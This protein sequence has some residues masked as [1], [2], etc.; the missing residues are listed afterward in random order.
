MKIKRALLREVPLRLREYFEIS[1]GGVQERRVVLL[2]LTDAHGVEGFSECVVPEKPNYTAETTDTAWGVLTEYVLP[3]IIGKEWEDPAEVL[4]SL[5]WIRGH[6]MALASVEMAAWDLLA[7]SRGLSLSETLGGTLTEVAVGVSVGLK[8]TDAELLDTVAAYEARGYARVKL[9]IKPGR[10]LEML[11][12]VRERFPGLAIMAD[13]N[14][15]YTMEDLPKFRE[16]DGLGLTMIEQPLAF[17][18]YLQHSRLQR[19]LSTPVCLDE[20]IRSAADA[21]LALALGSCRVVNIKPGRVGGHAESRQIHDLMRDRSLPVWCGGMLETGIGRAH[22]LAL[23]SLP[24]FTLPGDI[25]ESRR[26]WQRDIVSPEF[27]M[28]RGWMRVPTDPGIGV[29]IDDELIGRT[30][31]RQA[32]F[33]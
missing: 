14:S 6:R 13:A 8:P 20:S 25:S 23:A 28:D 27:V 4:A 32:D 19:E 29:E 22:N 33:R 31:V 10:D 2:R 9:K 15:A 3:R 21:E 1:S 18:D 17:D 26:Y 16:L 24:G 30:A 5:R 7:R 11:A 12:A